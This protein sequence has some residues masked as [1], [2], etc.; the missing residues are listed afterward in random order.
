M[1]Y[2]KPAMSL[3]LYTPLP[4]MKES[5]IHK[6]WNAMQSTLS[7]NPI[8]LYFKTHNKPY[9]KHKNTDRD[10]TGVKMIAKLMNL[11]PIIN[12]LIL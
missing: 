3:S 6:I 7:I 9:T 2:F 5:I 8:T 10:S 4:V 12:T 11:H 1:I